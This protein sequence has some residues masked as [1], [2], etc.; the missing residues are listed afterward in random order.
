MDKEV[1]LISLI[2][3]EFVSLIFPGRIISASL[4][5]GPRFSRRF[6]KIQTSSA[7][8]KLLALRNTR[9]SSPLVFTFLLAERHAM[10]AQPEVQDDPTDGYEA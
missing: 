10:E 3:T 5:T 9:R 4:S 7:R 2:Q 1:K 8:C 6:M